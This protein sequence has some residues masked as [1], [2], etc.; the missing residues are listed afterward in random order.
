MIER[1][2]NKAAEQSGGCKIEVTSKPVI[3]PPNS[4]I[5]VGDHALIIFTDESRREYIYR[6]GPW[7]EGKTTCGEQNGNICVLED[8]ILESPDKNV[9]DTSTYMRSVLLAGAN[10]CAKRTCFDSELQRINAL[11][12]P[13]NPV[14]GPNSHTVV[15]TMLRNCGLPEY[16]PAGQNLFG[17]DAIEALE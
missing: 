1:L 14:Q 15:R 9:S 2:A 3:F 17:W 7:V 12:M 11:K 10:A 8:P 13:Y 6:G 16:V 5:S 4:G